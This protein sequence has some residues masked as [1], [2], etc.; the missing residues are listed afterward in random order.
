MKRVPQ[1]VIDLME[2]SRYEFDFYKNHP[3]YAAGYT[4]T[5]KKRTHYSYATTLHNE[6][7]R[8]CRWANKQGA[9]TVAF[10]L[11]MPTRTLHSQQYAVVTIYDPVMQKIEQ[12]I[13]KEG[14]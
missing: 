2:R 9:G 12:Y 6:V 3:G 4:I 10:I 8:L 5:I 14:K 11:S 1:Y 13:P 7:D